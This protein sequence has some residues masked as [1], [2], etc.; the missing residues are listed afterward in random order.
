MD[1]GNIAVLVDAKLEYTNQLINILK[2]NMLF[3][4]NKIYVDIKQE[5]EEK[6]KPNLTLKNF[7]LKLSE[8][9]Q[10]NQNIIENY[11]KQIIE[12][13]NCDWLDELITAVFVSHTRILSSI[14]NNKNGSKINLKIPK[15]SNFIHKCFI[16]I[17]RYYWKNLYLLDEKVNNYQKQKNKRELEKLIEISINETIRKELPLK[18]ILKEYV[19]AVNKDNNEHENDVKNKDSKDNSSKGLNLRNMVINDRK[20]F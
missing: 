9:P 20:L 2:P 17:A 10:W 6:N 3:S 18:N 19:N 8:I 12:N 4:M 14:S 13:S 5:F 15:T 1:E 11:H 7:Q 16:D